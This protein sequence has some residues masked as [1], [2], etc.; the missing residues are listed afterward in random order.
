MDL[1]SSM[2]D[3]ILQHILFFVPTKL[4]IETSV[5]SKRWRQVWS[6]ISGLSIDDYKNDADAIN[7]T[8]TRYT[9]SKMIKFHLSS[10]MIKHT[11]TNINRW[12]EFAMSRNVE[13]LSLFV[14]F[15]HGYNIPD[16]F[17]ISS[18]VK[19]LCLVLPY[20]HRTLKCSASWTSLKKLSLWYCFLPDES[21]AKILYG[22]VVRFSKA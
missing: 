12:I 21:I 4:A 1:I 11:V 14:D 17:Y 19:Q 22:Y 2:P 10:C 8:L 6:N 16:L 18:S 9:A 5:L 15:V 3:V 7:E 20:F 13:D